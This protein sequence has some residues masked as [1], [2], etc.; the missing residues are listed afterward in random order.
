[1]YQLT[2]FYDIYLK[3]YHVIGL[4]L[5]DQ[6]LIWCSILTLKWFYRSV[7]ETFRIETFTPFFFFNFYRYAILSTM[8]TFTLC[9][10]SL[11]TRQFCPFYYV[12]WTFS[13]RSRVH[14]LCG[15]TFC[16]NE[17]SSKNEK[18][19]NKIETSTYN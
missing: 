3:F 5:Y 10:R 8:G 18:S 19:S 6:I 13:M 17:K 7:A 14:I 9:L 15:S 4:Y 11:W 2:E 16:A 12:N 1:M